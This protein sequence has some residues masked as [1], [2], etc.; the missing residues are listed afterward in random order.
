MVTL[1]CKNYGI[2]CDYVITDETED[3]Y[4]VFAEHVSDEHGIDV[5]K[6]G[7]GFN[8]PAQEVLTQV[9]LDPQSVH[10]SDSKSKPSSNVVI[11]DTIKEESPKIQN[12]ISHNENL[13]TKSEKTDIQTNDIELIKVKLDAII[14][15]V[16][17]IISTLNKK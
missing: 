7:G 4:D 9:I 3:M 2:E 13:D 14:V 10:H 11:S 15:I 16:N 1:S 17:E 6:Y 12:K 5:T 8:N